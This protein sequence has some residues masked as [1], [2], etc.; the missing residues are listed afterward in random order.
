MPTDKISHGYAPVYE[1]L[2]SRITQW[3]TILEVGVGDGSGMDYFRQT[4][5]GA[6]VFGIDNRQTELADVLHAEQ[7]DPQLAA[8]IQAFAAGRHQELISLPQPVDPADVLFDLVVDD[9]S[10]NNVLTYYTLINLWPVVRPGGFYVIEDWNHV[11]SIGMWETLS[12]VLLAEM[13][14]QGGGGIFPDQLT[15][16]SGLIVMGKRR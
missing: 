6:H 11:D 16:Q 1:H 15:V 12:P 4:F 2:A 8:R 9:A 5:K 13:L 14:G 3:P 10:H 7:D